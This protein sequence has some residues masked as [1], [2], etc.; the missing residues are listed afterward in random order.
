MSLNSILGTATSGLMVSQT[1]LKVVSD[2]IAN[3][4]TPGYVRRVV[5][6]Q[7]R[8]LS[9]LG[10]G[11]E[12]VGIRRVVD[13][14]LA[15]SSL[16]ASADAGS[17]AALSEML[18]RAQTLFGDPSSSSSFFNKLDQVWQAFSQTGTDP[19]SSVARRAALSA[20]SGFLDQAASL[21]G[22]LDRL[23]L[24]AQNRARSDVDQVNSLLAQIDELNASITRATVSGQDASGA[25]NAQ[26]QLIDK[27][28]Q[29]IDI[30]VADAG[31]GRI[32]IRGGANGTLLLGEQGAAV[33]GYSKD[34]DAP[35]QLTVRIGTGGGQPFLPTGGDLGGAL[36]AANRDL[37]N[38]A[39]ELSEYVTRAVEEINRAHN[40]AS[41][42][43]APSV[44]IGRD[45]GLDLPSA[46]SG[47]T[48]KTTISIVDPTN[49]LQS[50]VEIDFSAGTMSV[51]GGA[52]TGFTPSNFLAR[53]NTALGA[54]G[55]ASFTNGALTLSAAGGA[56]VAIT[57][58]AAT[59]SLQGGRGFSQFFGLNDLI[60]TSGYPNPATG[61]SLTDQHG[62]TPGGEI[63][64]RVSDA[65]GTALRDVKV[66]VPAAGTMASLISALNSSAGGVGLYGAFS[67]DAEGRMTFA[68]N[69]LGAQISVVGDT[70]E[71]GSGGPSVSQLFGLDAASAARRT[72]SFSIR[73]DISANP[74][75]LA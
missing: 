64:F 74:S 2:N 17:A 12:V 52:A 59:P 36:D 4:N 9:E 24:E 32:S 46:I 44:L 31:Q 65:S 45:T 7:S 73:G 18:D 41:A 16:N 71:R 15:Q 38:L 72:T 51:D 23:S 30:K 8:S 27:L 70:S 43:P 35:A 61:L 63:T 6:Q 29:L 34:G 42:I 55:S 10:G 5:D 53:L 69:G 20:V 60:S 3:I 11:V 39:L 13:Q 21:S 50:K 75:R 56:G 62:F 1:G 57:D 68:P 54:N 40:A 47:F 67:L 48:G 37:P 49:A 14:F 66:T 26:G 19:A 25:Q 28:S 33:L 22:D 58:D